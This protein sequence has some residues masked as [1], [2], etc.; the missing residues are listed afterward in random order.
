[1]KL[2][3]KI[4]INTLLLFA[5][6][7]CKDTPKETKQISEL[8]IENKDFTF[9]IESL[10]DRE[11][12]DNPDIGF[13]A[14]DYDYNYFEAGKIHPEK[15]NGKYSFYFY[16]NGKTGDSIAFNT[17][18]LLE[19]MPTVPE[20]LKEDRYLSYIAVVNQEWN[21]NQVRFNASQFQSSNK[22]IVRVDI[23]RNCLNSYLWEIIAYKKENGK[24][25]PF[26]HGWFDFPKPLYTQLFKARNDV[27]FEL[28]KKPLENWVDCENRKIKKSYISKTLDTVTISYQDKGNTMY[29]LEGARKKK[30]K[31]IIYPETFKTI[32]DLQSDSTKFA[33]FS[34][35]GFYNK[36]NPRKTELGRI[37]NL[38]EVTLYKV[39]S[40]QA[41]DTLNEINFTFIDADNKRTTKLVLGGLDLSDL[42]TLSDDKANEGWKNSMGFSNHPFYESYEQHLSWESDKN[43]YY[44]YL[45]DDKDNWLDSHL[46][47]IDGPVMYWDDKNPKMLHVWLLSFERH[48][49]V[50]HYTLEI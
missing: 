42:P 22:D 27:D 29:P 14:S 32:R 4:L 50:G 23:A 16:S 18:D 46:V 40:S 39:M 24:E 9:K 33:T 38:K 7:S 2:T 49:F 28:Y 43:P 34:P 37:R 21:R 17:I 48:A 8:T 26:S 45:T 11:Y 36:S 5:I 44:S 6:F 20:H 13:M 12:P 10:N 25:L 47:G 30:F 41:K 19:F 15:E 3:T 31:E 1:M 35:P